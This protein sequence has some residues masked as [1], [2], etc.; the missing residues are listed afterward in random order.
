MAGMAS[1]NTIEGVKAQ[2][3]SIEEPRAEGHSGTQTGSK[4]LNTPNATYKG[5]K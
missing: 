4:I 3:R 1:T 2:I 5:G